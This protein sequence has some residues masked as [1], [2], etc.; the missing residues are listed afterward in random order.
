MQPDN[1]GTLADVAYEL[2]L[3]GD[4]D[5]IHAFLSG[6]ESNKTRAILFEETSVPSFSLYLDI[7]MQYRC[8]NGKVY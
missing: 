2:T 4:T 8:R 7:S 1:R 5:A 3:P 6:N